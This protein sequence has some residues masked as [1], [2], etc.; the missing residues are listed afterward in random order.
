MTSLFFAAGGKDASREPF[1]TAA[2]DLVAL[3]NVGLYSDAVQVASPN[4]KTVKAN[5][6][7]IRQSRPDSGVSFQMRVLKIFGISLSSLGSG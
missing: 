3:I 2:H 1:A 6:A 5:V 4:C 7:H